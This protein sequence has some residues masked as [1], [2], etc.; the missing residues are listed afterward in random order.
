MSAHWVPGGL[1]FSPS[2]KSYTGNCT[3]EGHR[4]ACGNQHNAPVEYCLSEV[5]PE[6]C[7]VSIAPV[8]LAVVV[9]CN[10][11]K[12]IAF[13][14]TLCITLKQRSLVT[15]GDAVSSFLRRPCETTRGRCLANKA[16]HLISSK[17]FDTNTRQAT[18]S[19]S[20][21]HA[22][23]QRWGRS[24][25]TFLWCIMILPLFLLIFAMGSLFNPRSKAGSSIVH[26][27]LFLVNIPQLM[28]SYAYLPVNHFFTTMFAMREWTS[29]ATKKAKGLRVSDP[30][31]E[32]AQ[33]STYFNSL[34]LRWCIPLMVIFA[35]IHWS[36]SQILR[37]L[38]IETY[39]PNG[40]LDPATSGMELAFSSG[41]PR[42]LGLTLASATVFVLST[43]AIFR[44]FPTE[45]TLAG[46]CSASIAAACQPDNGKEAFEDGLE[47]KK[48][49]WG[50][51]ET[52]Q[53]GR[54]GHATFSSG[55]VGKLQ[56][57]ECY[58]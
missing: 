19:G 38:P 21:W 47:L 43:M 34:P 17:R 42:I 5:V 24:E 49:V 6:R 25:R 54:P 53:M 14:W 9:A 28:A 57:G 40:D 50:V 1:A 23:R 56:R 4:L 18:G 30:V 44:R 58:T 26:L 12:C 46:C 15:T 11:L 13:I 55:E 48:L 39:S 32:S 7:K 52:P 16:D 37:F 31:D 29:F 22:R 35:L 20:V 2:F 27:D 51:T 8:F 41:F 10:A 36:T 45:A 3:G 33:R